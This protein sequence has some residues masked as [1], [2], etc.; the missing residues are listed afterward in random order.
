MISY[1]CMFISH[2][3]QSTFASSSTSIKSRY[4][5]LF[6]T[7]APFASPFPLATE[8]CYQQKNNFYS[9]LPKATVN[10]T[11]GLYIAV[12]IHSL[13]KSLSISLLVP[14]MVMFLKVIGSHGYY[15]PAADVC[16]ISL[17]TTCSL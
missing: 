15:L 3:I 1:H 8:F 16:V 17:V 14:T 7:T 13:L 11:S 12:I 4:R 10:K 2:T 9:L 5:L 6:V